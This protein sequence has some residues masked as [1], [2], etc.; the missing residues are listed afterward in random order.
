MFVLIISG[1]QKNIAVLKFITV[2]IYV[3]N[4]R[5]ERNTCPIVYERPTDP[6]WVTQV[7]RF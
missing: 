2:Y 7:F 4:L 1:I 3:I 6:N 5:K